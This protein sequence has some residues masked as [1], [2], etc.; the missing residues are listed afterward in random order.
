MTAFCSAK[1]NKRPDTTV[2]AF[3]LMATTQILLQLNFVSLWGK[4]ERTYGIL[5]LPNQSRVET[6]FNQKLWYDY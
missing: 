3:I 1:D 6:K 4:L 2:T 5:I